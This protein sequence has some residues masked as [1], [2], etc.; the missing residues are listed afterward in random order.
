M[1][2]YQLNSNYLPYAKSKLSLVVTF[3]I[4]IFLVLFLSFASAVWIKIAPHDNVRY[5]A[6]INSDSVDRIKS[7]C[8]NDGQNHSIYAIGRPVAALLECFVF[9][10]VWSFND[11]GMMRTGVIVL[12]ALAATLL[13]LILNKYGFDQLSAV[14]TAIAI[15][16]LPGVQN[17]VFMACYANALTPLVAI[18]TFFFLCIVKQ[19][20]P[21]TN[22]SPIFFITGV[23]LLL[24]A[25]LTYQGLVF[26]YFWGTLARLL[27]NQTHTKTAWIKATIYDVAIFSVAAIAYFFTNQKFL[28]KYYQT[29]PYLVSAEYSPDLSLVSIAHKVPLFFTEMLPRVSA[30]W[31]KN[32]GIFSTLIL[33]VFVFSI[34][35]SIFLRK[36]NHSNAKTRLVRQLQ[37][38][39]AILG[40]FAFT[41][42]PVILTTKDHYLYQRLLL[43]SMGALIIIITYLIP[44][45]LASSIGSTARL[46]LPIRQ[47][48]SLLAAILGLI[49]A[50]HDTV[51]NVWGANMEMEFVRQKLAENNR[52][53]RRIHLVQAINNNRGFN[54]R[55]S[56]RDEFNKK[57]TDYI[58]DVHAFMQI[59]L[60]KFPSYKNIALVPCDFK[61][62][63]CDALVDKKSIIFSSSQ[64]G[65]RICKSDNM[66]LVDM[67]LL[68]RATGTGKPTLVDESNLPLCSI[69]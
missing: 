11:L 22:L 48:I 29:Q 12:L 15:F 63:H 10:H 50:S 44:S 51:L 28:P 43:P 9:K 69:K 5:F 25:M 13:G 54:G 45:L 68:V 58:N 30:L 37:I 64:Y 62:V 36:K 17:T 1:E 16:T 7:S 46:L 21:K 3:F 67:N 6:G 41:F 40:V 35:L 57:T 59:A 34:F 32:I 19:H 65:E 55:I 33:I 31:F 26:I 38:G 53:P 18:G 47:F 24:F 8:K 14:L 52:L 49:L 60:M 23:I 42:G 4:L 39:L 20:Y 2:A 66:L 56:Y 61:A 27:Y